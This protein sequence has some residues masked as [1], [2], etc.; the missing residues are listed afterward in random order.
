MLAWL[1]RH[2]CG[3]TGEIRDFSL[4]WEG[5]FDLTLALDAYSLTQAKPSCVQGVPSTLIRG[6]A[7]SRA[8]S[9]GCVRKAPSPGFYSSACGHTLSVMRGRPSAVGRTGDIM[10]WSRPSRFGQLLPD[11]PSLGQT[12]G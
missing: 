11:R 6:L 5:D 12:A 10:P 2:R 3:N 1:G 8:S 7:V 4:R 9:R